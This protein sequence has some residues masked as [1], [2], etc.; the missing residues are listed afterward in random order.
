M[1]KHDRHVGFFGARGQ[2]LIS[3]ERVAVVGC[4]G[5]GNHAVPQLVCLGVQEVIGID[6]EHLSETNRNR[7]T[8]ARR[9]DPA[10]GT[11]KVDIAQRAV[12]DIDTDVAFTPVKA[13]LRTAQVFEQLRR[14]TTIF[15]C[16]DNEGSRLVLM[17]FAC[18]HRIPYF[19]L[20][21]DIPPGDALN[22]GGRVAL[23]NQR[24]GCLVCMDLLDMAE[25]RADLES[26]SA[27]LDRE[28]IYGVEKSDLSTSGPSVVSLNGVVASLAVTEF[29]MHVT[30][31]RAPAQQ[32]SY[33]G[34]TGVVTRS[35]PPAAAAD[36]YYCC[37]VK[38]AGDKA[39]L[40][41]YVG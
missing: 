22:F 29:I 16:V 13:S 39:G 32:L 30:A 35:T 18:A 37:N 3:K 12:K 6:D 4:G 40:G 27:R 31:L 19:D 23:V 24:P 20:A 7:Y 11:H 21:T 26:E 9:S 2:E 38:G 25:A 14:A 34:R 8:L 28:R 36:C 10:P 17:E 5:L 41:R 1:H 33:R 15:G